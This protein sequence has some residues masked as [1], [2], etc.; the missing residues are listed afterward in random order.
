[1]QID[2]MAA[3]LEGLWREDEALA[4]VAQ[5]RTSDHWRTSQAVYEGVIAGTG[6]KVSSLG[7]LTVWNGRGQ[8][9]MSTS[10]EFDAPVGLHIA[11]QQPSA[12]LARIQA[13][14]SLLAEYRGA[15]QYY[16]RNSSAPAGEVTGLETALKIIASG[17]AARPGYDEGWRP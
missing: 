2:E 12:V 1:M 7:S 15:V 9:V 17:Y 14:R 4:L 10:N 8:S 16:D 6:E 5:K 13:E 3:W 11:Q